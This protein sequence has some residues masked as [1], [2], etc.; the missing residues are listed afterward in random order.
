VAEPSSFDLSCPLPIPEYPQVLLA[1]GGG[2]R[3]MHDLLERMILPA[4]A[5][6]LLASRHDSAVFDLGGIRVAFT[7]DGYVVRPLFFPGGDIGALAVNGTVND[8]AMAGA[9]PR[10]LSAALIIEEGFAMETLGRILA[11]M[12]AAAEAAG[13]LL[14]TGDTKVV[15]RGKGDGIYITTAGIGTIEHSL[16]IAP[17]SV[18]PG[19]AILL[20]GDIGRHGMA[21]M[22][23][24]EGLGF[25]SGIASD[26][27][28]L[29][30]PV[31][32]LLD[33]GIAVRCLRDCTRGGLASALIE[34][35]ESA[36]LALRIREQAIPVREDVQGAC[37]IL[38]FDPLYVANEGRFACFVPAADVDRALALLR[39]YPVTAGASLIGEAVEGRPGQLLLQSRIGTWRI[40]DRL[41]GEQ[42]PRLC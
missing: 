19:D 28:P 4:F 41:S 35:A 18:R 30:G 34:I 40:V 20:S 37:E 14:A 10:Y 17:P 33:A 11:S 7:T 39:E 1:H 36:R 32:A 6:P 29:Y 2:G 25:E 16:T 22:A 9:R 8:L 23:V 31:Q 21:V 3:L 24:R 12:R 42:L 27:A 15:D 13:V 26:C 5:N 38:G